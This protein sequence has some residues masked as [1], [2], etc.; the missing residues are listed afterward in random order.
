M[1]YR[2]RGPAA[3]L[4]ADSDHDI[5]TIYLGAAYAKVLGF[6]ARNWASAAKAGA[7]TDTAAKVKLTDA[8][9]VI[10]YLDAADDDYATA[11]VTKFIRA[12]DTLTGLGFEVV[13]ATGAA[14]AGAGENLVVASPVT[15]TVLNGGTATDYFELYLFVDDGNAEAP[16]RK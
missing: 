6:T 7:G 8:N 2:R 3:G 16:T 5:G 1:A 9:G 14:L 13:D 4:V 10:F 12:D 11:S 15:V